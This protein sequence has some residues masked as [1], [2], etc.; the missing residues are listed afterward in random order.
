[1][2]SSTPSLSLPPSLPPSLQAFSV[3]AAAAAT[4]DYLPHL[5]KVTTFNGAAQSLLGFV[6]LTEF[7]IIFKSLIV[8]N[9]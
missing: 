8:L 1:M 4:D 6:F 9:A 5:C 7:E 3:A 2:A